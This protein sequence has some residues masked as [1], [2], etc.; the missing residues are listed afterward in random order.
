ME[1]AAPGNQILLGNAQAYNVLITA[2]ALVMIFFALMPALIAGFGNVLVPIQIGGADMAFP[3][4]NSI[5]F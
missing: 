3:R 2:H 5:A 1:L 4:I